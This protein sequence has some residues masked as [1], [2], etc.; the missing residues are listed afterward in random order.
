MEEYGWPEAFWKD[1]WVRERGE[2]WRR[3]L[4]ELYPDF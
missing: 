1:D 3:L 2:L 4:N